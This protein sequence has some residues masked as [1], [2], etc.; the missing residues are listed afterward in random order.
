MQVP[1]PLGDVALEKV[2]INGQP[3]TLL[4]DPPAVSLPQSG[5]HVIDIHFGVP[6]SRLGVTGRM[7]VP[8]RE[9]AS[10]RLL[11]RLPADD[12]DVQISGCPG[13]WRRGKAV[14]GV[15][16]PFRIGTPET[17]GDMVSIPLG[18]A[19]DLSIRWQ[20]RRTD[21]PAG[22][23]VSVDQ[24]LLVELLDSG[25]H[26][27]STFHYRIQQGSVNRLQF[28][29]PPDLIVQDVHGPEV[30]DWSLDTET[31]GA[32]TSGVQKLIVSLKTEL[33]T[34][35]DVNVDCFRRDLAAAGTV[36][37]QLT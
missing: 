24:L 13:G 12:L 33:T 6:V 28:H 22:Q 19:G 16:T 27:H 20:P 26:L 34:G 1:L 35:T 4:G 25:I 2:E 37:V 32:A 18:A 5:L 3:A 21:A 8:L 31:A 14:P 29:V 30:A 17:A 15:L 36:S 23:L 9:V 7:T 10:G 11:F